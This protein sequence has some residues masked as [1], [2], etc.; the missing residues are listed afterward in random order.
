MS[1]EVQSETFTMPLAGREI[2][3]RRPALGQVLVLERMYHRE[4]KNNKDAEEKVRNRAM[5]GVLVRTLDFI[6]TL[7][8]V[9]DDRQFIEDQMLAGTIDWPDVMRVLSG[10]KGGDSGEDDEAPK[11]VKR[12][13]KKS[14]KAA[15][16]DLTGKKPAQIVPRP[17]GATSR[18]RTKR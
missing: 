3:F 5:T 15:S 1:D 8:V 16:V 12:A 11:P 7:V 6:D 9:E 4:V 13:P 17:T 2:E 14:P 10:G 18:A